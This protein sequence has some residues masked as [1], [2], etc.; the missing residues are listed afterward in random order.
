MTNS[1]EIENKISILE[2]RHEMFESEIARVESTHRN[3]MMIIDLKKKK[4]K[5][6]DE[7]EALKKQL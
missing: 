2:A 6:K 4:L 1:Q 7:I 5:I 3:E